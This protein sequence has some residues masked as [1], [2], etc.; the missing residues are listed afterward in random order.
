VFIPYHWG[1]G[2]AANNLTIRAYD[3]I[4]RIPEFKVCAVAIEK[5]PEGA[6][7][8]RDAMRELPLSPPRT[9]PGEQFA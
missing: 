7:V 4:S 1:G 9:M 6:T 8:T 5:A 3:P 2:Q